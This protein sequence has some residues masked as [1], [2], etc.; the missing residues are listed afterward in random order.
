VAQ[1]IDQ[2]ANIDLWIDSLSYNSGT[3]TVTATVNAAILNAI[4]GQQNLTLY[5]T[6]SHIIGWQEENGHPDIPDYEFNHV[7]RGAL[8]NPLGEAFIPGDAQVGDTLSTTFSYVLPANV[9]VPNNCSLVA[10]VYNTDA[11]PTQYQVQEAA[12]RKFVP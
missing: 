7:L 10:Y 6:E 1:L 5:L 4:P 11:G 3:N 9:L 2:P 12:E 8:N